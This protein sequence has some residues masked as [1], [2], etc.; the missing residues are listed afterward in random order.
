MVVVYTAGYSGRGELHLAWQLKDVGCHTGFLKEKA[1][2]PREKAG[3]EGIRIGNDGQARNSLVC[4]GNSKQVNDQKIK[5]EVRS[6]GCGG[7]GGDR[8]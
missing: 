5:S 3:E 8:D 7:R 4:T 2:E 1:A 6:G